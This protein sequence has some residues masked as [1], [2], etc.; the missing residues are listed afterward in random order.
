MIL[1]GLAVAGA[2]LF[3]GYAI[4]RVLIAILEELRHIRAKMKP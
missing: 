4:E 3:A 2:V 1:V